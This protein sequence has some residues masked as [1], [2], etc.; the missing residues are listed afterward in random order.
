MV[1]TWATFADGAGEWLRFDEEDR[2]R[3]PSTLVDYRSALKAHLMP[4][5]GERPL[6]SVTPEKIEPWRRSF[7]GLSGPEQEQAADPDARH[8]P[9]SADRLGATGQPPRPRREAPD[10]AKRR[11][12][13]V[14]LEEVWALVRAAAF[15][16][17]GALFLAAAFT[18][19][20]MGEL[21]ALR[22]R[23]VDFVGSTIRVRASYARGQP[24]TPESGT[25]LM[26]FVRRTSGLG[27]LSETS[28]RAGR[29]VANA[30]RSGGCCSPSNITGLHVD[31]DAGRVFARRLPECLITDLGSGL[32]LYRDGRRRRDLELREVGLLRWVDLGE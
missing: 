4:A 14:S 20:R 2:E 28:E 19:L 3:K 25:V 26:R 18:G 30:D 1:R 32:Q 23:D 27:S 6:E 24:T 29:E 9:P 13:G 21:L 7:T 8:L 10:E 17:D 15:E 22:G 12:P 5:F 31:S 16:Q 11:H